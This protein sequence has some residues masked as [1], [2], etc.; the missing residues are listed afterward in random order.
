MVGI[1]SMLVE[2]YRVSSTMFGRLQ[3]LFVALPAYSPEGWF[4]LLI[5]N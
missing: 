4:S 3:V 5:P 2:Q 1:N